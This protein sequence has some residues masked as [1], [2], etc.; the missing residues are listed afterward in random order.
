MSEKIIVAK[1][2]GKVLYRERDL[3]VKKF[4]A[5]YSKSDILNESLNQARVE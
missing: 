3:A 2:P 1:I 4:D 5:G